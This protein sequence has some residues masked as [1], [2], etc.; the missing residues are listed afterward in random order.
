M[1]A[2]MIF[3]GYLNFFSPHHCLLILQ[4]SN[5]HGATFWLTTHQIRFFL[6]SCYSQMVVEAAKHP[7]IISFNIKESQCYCEMNA[8]FFY[9]NNDL[10]EKN[11][12][13][14]GMIFNYFM[15]CI[16]IKRKDRIDMPY[17]ARSLNFS[18][19]FQFPAYKITKMNRHQYESWVFTFM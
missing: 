8:F 7:I 17:F 13:Q 3:K 15:L 16:K 19:S 1:Y 9:F 6:R 14:W 4:L 12:R 10:V 5:S 18:I 11:N 2:W